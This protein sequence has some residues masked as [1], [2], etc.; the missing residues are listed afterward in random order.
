MKKLNLFFCA[1]LLASGLVAQN[2]NVQVLVGPK[3][4]VE[5]Q[6]VNMS[7]NGRWACGNVNDGDGRGFVWDIVNDEI[8]QLAP[9]GQFAPVLDVSDDGTLVG[10]FVTNE[11]TS[12]G[13]SA[14]VGGFYKDGKW[15]YLPGCVM[16][17]GISDNGQYIAGITVTDSYR[18]ATWTIDG[19][20]TIWDE[21]PYVTGAY[22]S[23]GYDVNNDGTMVCGYGSHPDKKNRTPALWMIDES[24]GK[25]DSVLMDY[26]NAGPYSVAWNFSPDGTKISADKVVYDVTTMTAKKIDFT[27]VYDAET[28]EKKGFVYGYEFFRVTNKGNVVGNYTKGETDYQHAAYVIDGKIYDLQ[29]YLIA[30]YGI[31]ELKVEGVEFKNWKLLECTGISEDELVFAVTA[32]DM[33]DIPRP[34]IIRLDANT[35]NPAPTSL[36]AVHM[37]GTDVCRLTWKAPLANVEGVKAY[38]LWRNGEK[39]AEVAATEYSY[40]DSKVANGNYEYAVTA[41]YA[42]SESDK[43]EGTVVEVA[44][45]ATRAP[46]QLNAVQTGVCDVRLFWNAPLANRPSLKYGSATDNVISFGS[47]TYN[48]EQAVR[49]DA[50]DLAVYGGKQITDVTFYPMSK[51]NSWTVNF[52]TAKDTVLFASR[53]LDDSNLVYGVENTVQ[54][55]EPVTIPEGKDIYVGIFVDVTGYGGYTTLGAIF[56]TYRAGYTDLIRRQGEKD[57]MSLYENAMSNPEGAYEYPLT[58]PIGVCL[59]D[60]SQL[61]NYNVASYKVFMD[62]AEVGTTDLLKFRQG[63]V[64]DGEHTF[65]V[66]AVYSNGTVTEPVNASLTVAENMAAYKKIANISFSSADGKTLNASWEAPLDDDETNIGYSSDTNAGGLAP[67]EDSGYSALYAA[68]YDKDN[69]GLY[70]GYQITH[71]RF[72]PTADAEFAIVIREDGKQIVWKEL[73]R[74]VDYT[75]GMWNTIKLDEP[76]TVKSSSEYLLILDCYDVTPGSAPIGMDNLTPF[77]GESDLFSDD[78]GETF[79]SVSSMNNATREGNWMIGLVIRSTDSK[80]LPVEGYNVYVDRKLVN[81]S[82]L[83]ETTITHEV[84]TGTATHQVRVDVI[85]KD[86][87]KSVQGQTLFIDMAALGIEDVE[88]NV[89]TLAASETQITVVGGEVSSVKVYNVAGALVAQSTGATL[90][91]AHLESGIYVLTAVVDGKEVQRK[92]QVK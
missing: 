6:M 57:F 67:S 65:G 69:L 14:E 42:D 46:R 38:N 20:M 43:S 32:Y 19:T 25:R 90:D 36:K 54:L 18:M 9:I 63:T 10:L 72:F 68:S 77:Q 39:I 3:V 4:K 41:V 44:D 81:E 86:L 51:Q 84:G 35:V 34:L 33:E 75:K 78:N 91:V 71:V 29:E 74:G 17:Q 61:N 87:E 55:S 28:N 62:N 45:F 79:T 47:G 48:F 23:G 80:P 60:A 58:F 22:G 12:N 8:T 70:D 88:T 64:A 40:Y 92:I 52:Y 21:Y 50:T 37:E 31:G 5:Y 59:G 13:A 53:V 85:Y 16:A 27:G 7:A 26:S 24:T 2:G 89:I 66:A 56:N 30:K 1:S 15:H 76:I 73:E 83:T 82:P 49:F 11:A